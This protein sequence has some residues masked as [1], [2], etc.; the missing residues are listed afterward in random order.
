LSAKLEGV[1]V[2]KVATEIP[3]TIDALESFSAT[4]SK[5]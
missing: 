2:I 5:H 4:T 3:T 1:K